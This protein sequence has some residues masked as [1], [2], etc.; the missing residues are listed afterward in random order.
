MFIIPSGYAGSQAMLG[1]IHL[2]C[3]LMNALQQIKNMLF[4]LANY[5]FS[6][7]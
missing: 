4:F 7:F 2:K 1:H 6:P 3:S 5:E